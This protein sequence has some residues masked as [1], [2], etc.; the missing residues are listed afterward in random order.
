MGDKMHLL[1]ILAVLVVWAGVILAIIRFTANAKGGKRCEQCGGG[2]LSRLPSQNALKC[3]DCGH[4]TPWHKD[5][6][7]DDYY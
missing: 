2:Y 4:E 6:G 7:Q 3:F 1:S 5:E